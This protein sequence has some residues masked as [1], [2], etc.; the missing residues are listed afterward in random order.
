MVS[1]RLRFDGL[2]WVGLVW[3]RVGWV[4]L[5]WVGSVWFWLGLVL[6]DWVGLGWVGLARV[7]MYA[8]RIAEATAMEE[9]SQ[10]VRVGGEELP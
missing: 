3:L 10:S 7:A 2:A 4:G 9:F 8:E 6:F 1:F 5:G